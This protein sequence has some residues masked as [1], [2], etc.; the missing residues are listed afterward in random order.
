MDHP[1]QRFVRGREFTSFAVLRAGGAVRAL[2]TAESSASQLNYE[3]VDVEEIAQWVRTFAER[4]NLTGQLCFDFIQ[5]DET[6]VRHP[7][8]KA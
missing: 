3:H 1:V 5:D 4:T 7:F 2:T 6:K 8:S